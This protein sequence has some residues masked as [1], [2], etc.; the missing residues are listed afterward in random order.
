MRL[1][2]FISATAC[3]IFRKAMRTP[4]F[5]IRVMELSLLASMVSF[6]LEHQR[7]RG[8]SLRWQR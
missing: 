5:S 4:K 6:R 2:G 1:A 3:H 7:R 8:L